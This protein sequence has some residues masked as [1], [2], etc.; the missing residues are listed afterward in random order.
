MGP[1]EEQLKTYESHWNN[2]WRE[3]VGLT[4]AVIA[5][6]A[7]CLFKREYF[8][9]FTEPFVVGGLFAI[10]YYFGIWRPLK[11]LRNKAKNAKQA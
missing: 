7:W 4:L 9:F 5:L 8:L 1:D 11:K 2:R 6:E 10:Y 3:I